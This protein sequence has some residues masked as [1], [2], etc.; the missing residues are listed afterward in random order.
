VE[1]SCD[2]HTILAATTGYTGERGCELMV[3]PGAAPSLWRSLIADER[4][5]PAGLGARDTLRLEACYTLHGNDITPE[6]SAVSADLAWAC[7]FS[8]DFTGRELLFSEHTAAPA[9]RLVAVQMT[10][11]GIPRAGCCVYVGADGIG[12]VTSGTMSPTLGIGIALAYV[13]TELSAP[14]T[15]VEVDVRGTRYPAVVA[16]K[17]LYRREA[18][19]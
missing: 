15:E 4:V 5:V 10:G 8:K 17:P 9:Q 14:G 1:V 7:V 13:R 11:R 3:A 19:I 2:G 18:T 6:T 12:H 16:N